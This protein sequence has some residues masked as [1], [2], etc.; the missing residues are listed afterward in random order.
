MAC[1]GPFVGHEKKMPQRAGER[2]GII[3]RVVNDENLHARLLGR[4]KK[5]A[6]GKGGFVGAQMVLDPQMSDKS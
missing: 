6:V 1:G 4:I 2:L 3:E 5:F